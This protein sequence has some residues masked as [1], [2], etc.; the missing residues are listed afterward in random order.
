MEVPVELKRR[1]LDRRIL[2]LSHLRHL[3]D[4][5]DYSEALRVGHQ[6]KGNAQTF[7]L[8]EIVPYGIAIENAAKIKNKEEI[9][10]QISRMEH[11][12]QDARELV[13]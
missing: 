6:V 4:L 5:D 8:P 3:L 1:Y 9:Q 11:A 2:E 7:D 10:F 13:R 12:L